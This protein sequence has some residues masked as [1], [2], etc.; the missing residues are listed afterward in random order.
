MATFGA[1]TDAEESTPLGERMRAW[2]AGRWWQWRLPL[3]LVLAAQATRPLRMQGEPHI[4]A[5]IN[6][7]AHEFGHLFFAFF[8]E[9]LT[10][11]GGS[12]MQLLIP[13]GAAAVVGRSKD[14]FGVAVCGLFLAASLG[15]LS[16]YIADARARELDLVSFSPDTSGHD[17][18][19]LLRKAGMLRHDLRLARLTKFIGWILVFA[20]S[21]FAMR[22][23]YWMKTEP[24]KSESA[25]G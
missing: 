4:F 21:F 23:L 10:I 16:W 24:V 9:W 12:L 14:W 5:G 25:A 11:A 8:G 1:M 3:F 20:S 15:D 2:C 13:I 17:W 18:A 19:Y 22:L 7:G 6:F